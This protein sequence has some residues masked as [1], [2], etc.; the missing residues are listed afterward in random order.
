MLNAVR[1]PKV[2]SMDTNRHS[3][4]QLLL[5]LTLTFR[6]VQLSV[7]HFGNALYV[8]LYILSSLVLVTAISCFPEETS[9]KFFIKAAFCNKSLLNTGEIL[10]LS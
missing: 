2:P 9:L 4:K 5:Q 1:T 3:L 8:L 10:S 7:Q 6:K